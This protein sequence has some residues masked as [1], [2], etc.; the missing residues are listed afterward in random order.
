MDTAKK[1]QQAAMEFDLGVTSELNNDDILNSLQSI[2]EAEVRA[3]AVD[4]D[5]LLLIGNFAAQTRTAG[6][7]SRLKKWL[8]HQWDEDGRGFDVACSFLIAFWAG[9]QPADPVLAKVLLT[10]LERPA[11]ENAARDTLISALAIAYKK[12]SPDPIA[13]R[14]RHRFQE[15]MR[16]RPAEEYQ[17]FVLESLQK[18]CG[19]KADGQ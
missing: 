12:L 10:G 1:F 17:P 4:F 14:I 15:F 8:D 9:P 18:V 11:L 19:G 7:E 5:R 3:D 13:T 6:I 16:S 2:W